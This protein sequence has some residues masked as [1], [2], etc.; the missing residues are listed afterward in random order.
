MR[1]LHLDTGRTMRGGQHQALLL[2]D[3]Q[4]AAGWKPTLLTG[5]GIRSVRNFARAASLA[6][7]RRARQCDVI[8][9]HDAR[10]H[11]LAIL[12][13]GGKPVVVARRVAFPIGRGIASR[14]KYS[15]A[16]HFVAVSEHVAEVLRNGGVPAQK[17]TVAYDAAP[18]IDQAGLR[19]GDR[20]Q[21]DGQP[22]SEFCVVSP[23]FSDPLKASDLA[24]ASCLEAGARLVLSDDLREDLAAADAFLYLTK[25]EGL[26]SAILLAMSMGVPVIAS[27][28]GGIPEIVADGHTGLL[29]ENSV[30]SASKAILEL[31]AN[32]CLRAS[33]ASVARERVRTE[34][35]VRRM[36]ERTTHAYR[37]ALA[38]TD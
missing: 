31:H 29:V 20:Q 25:S 9:A 14:W 34:F 13:G 16:A 35:S 38:R 32:K 33:F 3:A 37:Q 4:A 28:V 12:H 21:A 10:S 19:A 11:T 36:T 6:V 8:H 17:I 18:E 5:Q 26:G 15:K 30:A 7:R 23:N 22:L 2:Y 1:V 27:A 24:A